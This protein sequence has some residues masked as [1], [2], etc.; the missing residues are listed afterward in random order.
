MYGKGK[1]YSKLPLLVLFLL[2]LLAAPV[3]LAYDTL[4]YFITRPPCL[5][6]QNLLEFLKSVSLTV[7][8][9]GSVGYQLR[10]KK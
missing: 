8:V 7:A 3:L 6:C 9:L 1:L 2:A 5:T 10:R 4:W